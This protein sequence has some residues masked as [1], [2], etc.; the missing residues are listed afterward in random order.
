MP[1]FEYS[2]DYRSK[3]ETLKQWKLDMRKEMQRIYTDG[4]VKDTNKMRDY[5]RKTFPNR[6]LTLE[7][8]LEDCYDNDIFLWS[9]HAVEKRL[10]EQQE[11]NIQTKG[12]HAL[13]G[14]TIE[15]TNL[16]ICLDFFEYAMPYT[17]MSRARTSDQ[18]IWV[19]TK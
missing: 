9:T 3:D 10:A 12:V 16:Y 14:Q 13:Q 17:A 8:A 5:I 1:V 11:R 15:G 6:I 18:I 19:E 2:T 7:N 4:G